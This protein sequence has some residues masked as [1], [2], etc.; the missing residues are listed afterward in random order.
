MKCVQMLMGE[1]R[2]LYSTIL[3]KLQSK[4]SSSFYPCLLPVKYR[5][6]KKE[7]IY[8]FACIHICCT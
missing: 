5:I 1:S 4:E 3:L 2:L 8:G 7:L 6:R